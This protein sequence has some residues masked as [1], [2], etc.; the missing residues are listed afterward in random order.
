[1]GFNILQ[2]DAAETPYGQNTRTHC[3]ELT[4]V[5]ARWRL[6]RSCRAQDCQPTKSV[7]VPRNVYPELLKIRVHGQFANS[8]CTG[9]F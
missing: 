7:A 6:G 9:G 8:P 2:T 1:M 4:C 5:P 3:I